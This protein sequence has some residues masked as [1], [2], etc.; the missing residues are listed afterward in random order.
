[1]PFKVLARDADNEFV[2]LDATFV[3][4]H[5][6]SAGA[7]KKRRWRYRKAV[8][9]TGRRWFPTI[10]SVQRSAQFSTSCLFSCAWF[11]LGCDAEIAGI[12]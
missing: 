10:S 11:G 9:H 12:G 5:Q 1:M 8:R 2:M 6:H 7:Q 4:A 3:R